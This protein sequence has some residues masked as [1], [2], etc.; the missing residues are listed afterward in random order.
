MNFRSLL[1]SLPLWGR[2]LKLSYINL[3]LKGG[4]KGNTTQIIYNNVSLGAEGKSRKIEMN[5]PVEYGKYYTHFYI[6][7]QNIESGIKWKEAVTV[8]AY[9]ELIID[10]ER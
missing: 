7:L 4:K 8:F 5:C 6:Y 3:D 9:D 10:W 1:Q 2:G